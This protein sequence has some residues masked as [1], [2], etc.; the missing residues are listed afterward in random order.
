MTKATSGS[1]QTQFGTPDRGRQASSRA[2]ADRRCQQPGCTTF[3]TTY[4]PGSTCW[5]HS[6]SQFKH[7]LARG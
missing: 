7:P 1:K 6:S 2:S 3:L 5:L 4:N